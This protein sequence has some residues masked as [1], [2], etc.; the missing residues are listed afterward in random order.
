M[1]SSYSSNYRIKYYFSQNL[2]SLLYEMRRPQI[3]SAEFKFYH[4]AKS[5]FI[6][7]EN[8]NFQNNLWCIS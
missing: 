2:N 5:L 1:N 3:Y 6:Y 4:V 7:F 8:L